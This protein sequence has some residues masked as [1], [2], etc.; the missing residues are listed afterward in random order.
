M[1]KYDYYSRAL[2]DVGRTLDNVHKPL[3][4]EA[5]VAEDDE[6]AWEEVGESLRYEYG[7]V[8]GDYSDAGH[9]FDPGNDETLTAIR[10]HAA[11]RFIVGGPETVTAEIEQYVEDLPVNEFLLRMHFPGLDPEKTEKSMRLLAKEVMPHFRA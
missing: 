2:D 7:D 5:Y 1:K 9:E 6:T 4:R 3:R 10:Q 8:Y 11:D